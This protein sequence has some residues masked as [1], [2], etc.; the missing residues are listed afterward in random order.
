LELVTT[1]YT[2]QETHDEEIGSRPTQRSIPPK[3]TLH[4]HSVAIMQALRSVVQYYPSQD[5]SE[6]IIKISSPYA[7]LVHH[8][9]DLIRYRDRCRADANSI[10]KLC[11]REKDAYE[12]IGVLKEFLDEVIM[13]AVEKERARN[14]RGFGTFDM[15]WVDAK[16]GHADEFDDNNEEGVVGIIPSVSGGSFEHPKAPWNIWYWKLE[17]DGSEIGRHLLSATFAVWDGEATF[18]CG[19]GA[20][21]TISEEGTAAESIRKGRLFWSLLRKQCR[22]CKGQ[23]KFFPHNEVRHLVKK[24]CMPDKRLICG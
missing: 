1:L 3:Q 4:I 14:L 2:N 6:D 16:P 10:N 20:I 12:H 22:Y 18:K 13:P 9:E 23:T 15:F 8:Y 11:F 5:L 24:N 17:Y 7:V 21:N 19:L